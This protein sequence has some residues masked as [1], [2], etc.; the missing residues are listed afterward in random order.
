M[1]NENGFT[2]IELMIAIVILGIMASI[3]VPSFESF[4]RK[5]QKSSIYNNLVGTISLARLEAIKQSRVIAIC[6]SSDQAT[7]SSTAAWHNG[8]MVFVDDNGNGALDTTNVVDTDGDGT[9]DAPE[10]V[11][12]REAAAPVGITITSTDDYP[13]LLTIAPR[14]RLRKEGTFLICDNGNDEG[15]MALNLWVTGL[16]RMATDGNDDDKIV[17]DIAGT[18]VSCT[19]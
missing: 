10:T 11:L 13:S 6:V 2:L 18:N 14:G 17:E 7:C 3:A 1:K 5:N 8:W 15:A 9:G 19:P 12:K 16:G 4:L